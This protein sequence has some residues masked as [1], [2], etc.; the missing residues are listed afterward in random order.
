MIE[1]RNLYKKYGKECVLNIISLSLPE[2]GLIAIVGPSGC[3]K[4]SLL[5]C[6][7]GLCDFRGQIRLGNK[8]IESLSE[9]EKNQLR[10]TS[11]G[12]VF[13]DFKLYECESVKQ[14]ILLPLDMISSDKTNFTTTTSAST[15][16]SHSLFLPQITS[17]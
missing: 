11:Y 12:F 14:N 5:N 13:Q 10:L 2:T 16:L 6:I 9:S 3:G 8:N 1:I 17:Y 15:L 4:T 7:A